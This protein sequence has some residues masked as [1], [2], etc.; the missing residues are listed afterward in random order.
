MTT[1]STQPDVLDGLLSNSAACLKEIEA[2]DFENMEE[3]VS[4][5]NQNLMNYLQ[6][7]EIITLARSEQEKLYRL[8]ND[9]NTAIKKIND[10]KRHLAR[11]LTELRNGRN[12]NS[13][14]KNN[15]A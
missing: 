8:L 13:T 4:Q 14:Y 7:K 5:H 6:G 11:K 12:L 3:I 2:G 15:A 9:Q 10:Q 1:T